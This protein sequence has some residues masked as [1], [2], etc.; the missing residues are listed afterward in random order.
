MNINENEYLGLTEEQAMKKATD[1]GLK[2][3][4]VERNGV[5]LMKTNGGRSDRLNLIIKDDKVIRV[6][7]A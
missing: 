1:N 2:V 7:I 5:G 6:F 4:T 3:R